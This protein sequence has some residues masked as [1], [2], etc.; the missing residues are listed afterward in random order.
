MKTGNETKSP[1]KSQTKK[2]IFVEFT[3]FEITFS[4]ALDPPS[5]LVSTH[6]ICLFSPLIKDVFFYF[7]NGEARIATK[8]N[9]KKSKYN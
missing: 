8:R 9:S 3:K 4:E 1:F 7:C 2:C 5:K 6:Y